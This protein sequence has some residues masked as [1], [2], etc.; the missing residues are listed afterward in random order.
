MR[1]VELL[2]TVV[3]ALALGTAVAVT[4]SA[5]TAAEFWFARAC[6]LAAAGALGSAYV[7]WLLESLRRPLSSLIREVVLGA[8]TA[9]AVLAGTPALIIWVNSREA[10]VA[11]ESARRAK[12]EP[13]QKETPPQLQL[14]IECRPG[15]LPHVFPPSGRVFVVQIY[16]ATERTGLHYFFGPSGDVFK[17]SERFVAAQQCEVVNYAPTAL[18]DV[19]MILRTEYLKIINQGPS[20]QI[21]GEVLTENER[22][23]VIPRIEPGADRSFVFYI[24]SNGENF[25][26]K[27]TPPQFASFR[28]SAESEERSVKLITPYGGSEPL[29][30]PPYRP[31]DHH[32]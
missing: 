22:M 7:V 12:L 11:E 10:S 25:F 23:V 16:N 4:T 3:F 2:L 29:F 32:N 15:P 30:L 21:G 5:G 31:E 27:I 14:F 1:A 28:V 17:V 13:P 26:A 6:Y 20:S 8:I 18:F 19:K 9:I 24:Y